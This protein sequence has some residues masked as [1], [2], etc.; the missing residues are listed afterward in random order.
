MVQDGALEVTH[1]MR[2]F[3]FDGQSQ[4]PTPVASLWTTRGAA[5]RSR[6]RA[7]RKLVKVAVS[8]RLPSATSTRS[9]SSSCCCPL[10]P[11]ARGEVYGRQQ[12]IQTWWFSVRP[13][14]LR[15]LCIPVR[16][17]CFYI[18]PRSLPYF[19]TR[20]GGCTEN[21]TAFGYHDSPYT[22]MSK[23]LM[24]Y[25]LRSYFVHHGFPDASTFG[26]AA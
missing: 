14:A 8:V 13:Y 18:L 6:V 7:T 5:L 1:A 17:C 26:R 23:G 11:H 21:H 9:W 19:L 12:R 16:R 10:F 20:V 4:R 22:P 24:A 3:Q 15:D 25:T 2:N